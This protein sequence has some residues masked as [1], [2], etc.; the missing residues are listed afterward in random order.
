M[1]NFEI[2]EGTYKNENEVVLS[3]RKE[4]V[5][6]EVEELS[7]K[8]IKREVDKLTKEIPVLIERKAYLESLIVNSKTEVMN[9]IL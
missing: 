5:R 1:K 8:E 4:V 6:E 9:A 7:V 2:K 3:I